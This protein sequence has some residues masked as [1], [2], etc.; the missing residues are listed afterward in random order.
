MA[1]LRY[2]NGPRAGFVITLRGG[3]VGGRGA[4]AQVLL[5]DVNASRRHF[6]FVRDGSTLR[7]RDLGAANGT[8]VN[9]ARLGASHELRHGDVLRVGDQTFLF[10]EG[11][12]ASDAG[13][14]PLLVI[15]E[16]DAADRVVLLKDR[17]SIGRAAVADVQLTTPG[18]STLHAAI[19]RA[20]TGWCV[21]DLGCTNGTYVNG[22]LLEAPHL[23]T[24][25]D[26]IALGAARALFMFDRPPG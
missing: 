2:Q 3:E 18:L 5:D 22:A 24:A 7:V 12:A 17:L 14:V 9:G 16:P 21:R 25:G 8:L 4:D 15:R 20:P 26:L 6:D 1:T 11:G 19:E 23:L 13:T 10:S